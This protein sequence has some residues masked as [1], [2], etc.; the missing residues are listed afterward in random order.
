[1]SSPFYFWQSLTLQSPTRVFSFLGNL[2]WL[3][4]ARRNCCFLRAPTVPCSQR[5]ITPPN[6]GSP[7]N[8]V[9]FPPA[10]EFLRLNKHLF[11][12]GASYLLY[13]Y[14]LPEFPQPRKVLSLASF[15]HK[16]T[17]IQSLCALPKV[18]ELVSGTPKS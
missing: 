15:Y 4:S 8:S 18:T 2:S 9:N 5:C 7:E 12:P 17:D 13:K 14:Q 11:T 10:A 6:P 3:S 1:M 16:E